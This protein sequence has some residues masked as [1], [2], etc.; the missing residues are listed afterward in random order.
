MLKDITSREDVKQLVDAFYRLAIVD[1]IIGVFFTSVIQLDWE[2]HIPIMYDFWEMA[3]FDKM[4]YSG[5]PM[6]KHI[7]LD[8]VSKLEPIH[9]DR[10][11]SLFSKTID[12]M[13]QGPKA[14]L[15]KHKAESMRTLML[16]KIKLSRGSNF[17]Q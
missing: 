16:H 10:W 11:I 1:D 6:L 3:L 4:I 5:N 7:A 14:D 15:A 2:K 12:E 9:F 17:I 8:K 13:Y